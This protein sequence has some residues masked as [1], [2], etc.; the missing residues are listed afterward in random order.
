MRRLYFVERTRKAP[1]PRRRTGGRSARVVNA[2]LEATVDA[3]AHS[4]YANLSFDEVAARAGVSRTTIYRRWATKHDL[5]RAALLRMCEACGSSARAT[6]TLRGDLLEL[7]R[8]RLVDD[9]R[10][11]ERTAGLMRAL[12]AEFDDSELLALARLIRDRM[13]QPIVAAIERGIARGELPAGTDPTLV[14]EPIFAPLY[15]RV[16]LFGET[17]ELAEAG[18]FVDVVLAG[19]R[20]GAAVR[21]PSAA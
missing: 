10:E 19:A 5:V 2:V 7:I 4:G 1:E 16:A 11:R 20:S 15:H 17:T 9:P 6:G 18:R 14:M 3:L 21:R 8:A 13:T 12:M